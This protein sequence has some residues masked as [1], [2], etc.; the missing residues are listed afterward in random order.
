MTPRLFLCVILGC[1][2]TFLELSCPCLKLS[3]AGGGQFLNRIETHSSRWRLIHCRCRVH[4]V[5]DSRSRRFSM[6]SSS[7]LGRQAQDGSTPWWYSPVFTTH[8]S[9]LT[10]CSSWQGNKLES[11]LGVTLGGLFTIRAVFL[12]LMPP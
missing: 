10:S 8:H 6:S 3:K 9:P 7:L 5:G 1:P 4:V 11:L 12:M 2:E